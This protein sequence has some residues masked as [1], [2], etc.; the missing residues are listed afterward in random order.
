MKKKIVKR[1]SEAFK[2]QVVREYEAGESQPTLRRKYGIQG[3]NT[4][5][6]WVR[7]YGHKG[8]RHE[9][10]V[11]QRAEEQQEEKAL[12]KRIKQ[13][14]AAVAQLTLDKMVLEVSLAEAEKLLGTNVKKNDKQRS[15][16]PATSTH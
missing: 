5:T 14:E 3:T 4:I 1:Y 2:K 11:I 9:L 6:Y 15:S 16:K 12:K 8:L 7:K 13:L 10:V